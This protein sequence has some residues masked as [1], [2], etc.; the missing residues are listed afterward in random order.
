[1][2]G[3]VEVYS[4]VDRSERL[5]TFHF[6]RQQKMNVG[7]GPYQFLT[8]NFAMHPASSVSGLYFSHSQ[9]RYFNL[10]KVRR[11][12]VEDYALRRG[13]AV[14]ESEK[15]LRPH[16]GYDADEDAPA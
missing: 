10:G 12:Q 11:D 7:K 15:W 8:E 3:D 2:G 13:Q 9:A 5:T 4:D 6:L 14:E 1:M 16:L